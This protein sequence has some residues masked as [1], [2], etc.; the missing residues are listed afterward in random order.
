[1]SATSWEKLAEVYENAGIVLVLGAGVS[2]ACGFPSWEELIE[3]LARRCHGDVGIDQVNRLQSH[4]Y[5]LPTIASVIAS[6][7]TREYGETQFIEQLRD[8]LYEGLPPQFYRESLTAERRAD[9][10]D[11]IQ[12][13][14]T[15][16]RTVAS[17]CAVPQPNGSYTTN[18]RIH[19]AATFNLDALLHNYIWSRYDERLLRIIDRASAAT[20]PGIINLYHVHGYLRFDTAAG[21]AEM[22]S[23]DDI[24]LTEQQYYDFFNRPN[25][26]FNYTALY[27]LREYSNVFIGLSMQDT[28]L[29]RLL[30][31]SKE[32]REL[33]LRREG[34]DGVIDVETQRHFA[35]ML[36]EEPAVDSLIEIS[37]EALG[38]NVL[39]IDAFSEIPERFA[40]VYGPGWEQ[41]F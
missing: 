8:S 25:S 2:R 10:V 38:V 40:A 5:S 31:Y 17:L 37:L 28:N 22:E 29:R 30:H 34:R 32:E 12:Q 36:R 13:T 9:F 6:T 24:L 35:V 11:Y 1:M 20:L 19:A 21:D 39:W 26:I 41:V 27:L 18:P 15:T 3:R 7:Y 14:N 4:D 16:L 23:V 33:G